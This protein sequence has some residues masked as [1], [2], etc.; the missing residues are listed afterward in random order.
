MSTRIDDL[1]KSIQDLMLQVIA[2]GDF[3]S[4]DPAA[5]QTLSEVGICSGCHEGL[6]FGHDRATMSTERAR[7]S[8]TSSFGLVESQFLISSPPSS[9]GRYRTYCG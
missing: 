6:L 3:N 8:D 2:P 5:R 1:E 4:D 9:T 7:N